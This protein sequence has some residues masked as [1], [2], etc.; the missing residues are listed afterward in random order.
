MVV[1]PLYTRPTIPPRLFFP[2]VPASTAP[3]FLQRLMFTVPSTWPTI[4][5]LPMMCVSSNTSQVARTKPALEQ[6]SSVPPFMAPTTPPQ[7]S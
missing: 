7:R 5:P 2:F 1:V 6:F 4:P 3:V